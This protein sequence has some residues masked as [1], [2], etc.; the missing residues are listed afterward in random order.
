ML[1]RNCP[2]HN[3]AK[4]GWANRYGEAEYQC[5]DCKRRWYAVR[6]LQQATPAQR[7]Q[8]QDPEEER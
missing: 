7:E 5:R 8:P 3:I 6:P 1:K 2:H 4:T